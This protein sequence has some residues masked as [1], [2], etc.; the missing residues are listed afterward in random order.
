[1]NTIGFFLLAFYTILGRTLCRGLYIGWA[2]FDRTFCRWTLNE[3]AFCRW[4]FNERALYIWRFYG[5]TFKGWTFFGQYV[6]CYRFWGLDGGGKYFGTFDEFRSNFLDN[7]KDKD[8]YWEL[9]SKV[10]RG[11]PF[12]ACL[13]HFLVQGGRYNC[14]T[15]VRLEETSKFQKKVSSPAHH[16][17]P[18]HTSSL[19]FMKFI[20]S[21]MAALQV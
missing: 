4:T 20:I 3:R 18:T 2:Y 21:A 14:P 19:L 12:E 7:A 1:M 17:H 10:A 11:L 5:R 8:T 15:M 6:A 16:V 13:L 9:N